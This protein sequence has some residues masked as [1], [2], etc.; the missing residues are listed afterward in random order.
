MS[1]E[2]RTGDGPAWATV[3]KQQ[4]AH[5]GLSLEALATACG[6]AKNTVWRW[7]NCQALPTEDVWPALQKAL[8]GLPSPPGL[9][10]PKA[11]YDEL[12]AETERLRALAMVDELT[13]LPNSRSLYVELDKALRA[14]HRGGKWLAIAHLDLDNFKRFNDEDSSHKTGDEALKSFAACASG[15]LRDDDVFAR[16]G[17]EEFVAI[18][19]DANP[20]QARMLAERIRG[21]VEQLKVRGHRVTVSIGVACVQAPDLSQLPEPSKRQLSREQC[22]LLREQLLAQADMATYWAK[23]DGRNRVVLW[24]AEEKTLREV[25]AVE[26]EAAEAAQ[27]AREDAVAKSSEQTPAVAAELLS[28][29]SL[30]SVA[31]R[32]VRFLRVPAFLAFMVLGLASFGG[33]AGCGGGGGSSCGPGTTMLDGRCVS[34]VDP[35]PGSSCTDPGN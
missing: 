17:G 33:E 1:S 35:C 14:A 11:T 30:V 29:T 31:Q 26:R 7:E 5:S 13:E 3:L 22:A 21:R 25:A 28:D 23:D 34:T 16:K 32:A 15:S 18:F 12:L 2:G 9:G 6:L 19:Q 4:R 8:P 10:K 27:R 20:Q 24:S